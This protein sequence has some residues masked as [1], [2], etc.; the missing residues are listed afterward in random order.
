MHAPNFWQGCLCE[1]QVIIQSVKHRLWTKPVS[2]V[3]CYLSFI[4]LGETP[5]L[6]GGKSVKR[7]TLS[8]R[9]V[10]ISSVASAQGK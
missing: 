4:S 8:L 6:A 3:G 7:L 5:N 10:L 2:D 1:L 9:F